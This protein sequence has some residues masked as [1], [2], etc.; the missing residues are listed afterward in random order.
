MWERNVIDY[1]SHTCALLC[2]T[3]YRLHQVLSGCYLYVGLSLHILM[4][5]DAQEVLLPG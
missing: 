2:R 4:L 5:S 3:L 1:S